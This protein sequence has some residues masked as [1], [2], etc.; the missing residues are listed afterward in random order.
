MT[1]LLLL[2]CCCTIGFAQDHQ[3]PEHQPY[4]PNIEPKYSRSTP[5][6]NEESLPK[7]VFGMAHGFPYKSLKK[8][9]DRDV[10]RDH[11]QSL[12]RGRPEFEGDH[13]GGE[14]P[15]DLR[16]PYFIPKMEDSSANRKL[17]QSGTEENH[18]QE[19]RQP[20][21]RDGSDEDERTFPLPP[22]L[23]IKVSP[24]KGKTPRKGNSYERNDSELR[25]QLVN[26][27]Q[28]QKQVPSS[29]EEHFFGPEQPSISNSEPEHG[30]GLKSRLS[31]GTGS[32]SSGEVDQKFSEE[33]K[34]EAMDHQSNR[35]FV[36][37]NVQAV[38]DVQPENRGLGPFGRFIPLRDWKLKQSGLLSPL[39]AKRRLRKKLRRRFRFPI[40]EEQN[41]VQ[42]RE[43]NSEEASTKQYG[44]L[45]VYSETPRDASYE[46]ETSQQ[47]QQPAALIPVQGMPSQT[48]EEQPINSP[49]RLRHFEEEVHQFTTRSSEE[50]SDQGELTRTTAPVIKASRFEKQSGGLE[51]R[52]IPSL[53]N[54]LFN[55]DMQE[56]EQDE[57]KRMHEIKGCSD[58]HGTDEISFPLREPCA[59][60]SQLSS[61]QSVS[62]PS[63]KPSQRAIGSVVEKSIELPSSLAP[64]PS[65]TPPSVSTARK[66]QTN[67]NGISKSKHVDC[68]GGAGSRDSKPIP[69][70][71]PSLPA[72][73]VQNIEVVLKYGDD[74]QR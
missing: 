35:D 64:P 12:R 68:G 50:L 20:Q 45:N 70:N 24:F 72:S 2:I 16:P 62:I 53:G 23:D 6:Q 46:G 59:D 42:N 1:M 63:T 49:K 8:D 27:F 48:S 4:H 3:H 43:I 66:E 56:D 7:P 65:S 38:T 13:E 39:S 58:E 14:P 51:Q 11:S 60:C 37:V 21:P 61:P 18:F 69:S 22:W 52:N 36:D 9:V 32:Q 73:S 40:I 71:T 31:V 44:D 10:D 41:E 26:G 55:V 29:H 5:F 25:Q 33:E 17:R 15:E 57:H 30:G 54:R 28:P 34:K 47:T 19:E 74:D 67:S